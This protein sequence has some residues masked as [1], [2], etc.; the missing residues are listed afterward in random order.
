[1]NGAGPP[2]RATAPQPASRMLKEIKAAITYA[3]L[4]RPARAGPAAGNTKPG[5]AIDPAWFSGSA[6]RG[7]GDGVHVVV[8]GI[9]DDGDPYRLRWGRC[10][11]GGRIRRRRREGTVV[12][13]F[14]NA[15]LRW[16]ASEHFFVR[17]AWGWP[18][19]ETFH[20][21]GIVLLVGIVGMFDAEEVL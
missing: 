3:A 7:A 8:G 14:L 19:C 1:M 13:A 4:R 6:E 16:P 11:S 21:F 9:A 20:F 18:L 10:G 17:Y 12:I 15:W 5:F 2:G